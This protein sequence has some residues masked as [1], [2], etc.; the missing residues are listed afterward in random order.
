MSFIDVFRVCVC[1][2]TN[3]PYDNEVLYVKNALLVMHTETHMLRF[4]LSYALFILY[5]FFFFA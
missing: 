4:V 1:V 2:P 5:F 3:E